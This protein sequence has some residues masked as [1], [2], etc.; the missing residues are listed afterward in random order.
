MDENESH[1]TS[2]EDDSPQLYKKGIK[3]EVD[4]VGPTMNDY[5]P[6]HCAWMINPSSQVS[7][8]RH[9]LIITTAPLPA[10]LAERLCGQVS[11]QLGSLRV[12]KLHCYAD[13]LYSYCVARNNGE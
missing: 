9:C 12:G 4:V 11:T 13:G 5:G 2:L 10:Y 6:T 7:Q 1:P 3:L 8:Q